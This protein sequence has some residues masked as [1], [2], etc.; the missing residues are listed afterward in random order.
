MNRGD[1]YELKLTAGTSGHEQSG[2]RYAIVVQATE[3]A[4]LSTVIVAP[5]STRA[6]PASFRP[7]VQVRRRRTMVLC[8]QLRALD[9]RRL[10]ERVGRLTPADMEEIDRALRLMLCL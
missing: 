7:E 5:T 10:R 1:I 3:L 4:P 6:A 2:K 8:D 9:S